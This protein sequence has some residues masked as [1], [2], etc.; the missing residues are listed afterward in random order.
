[1][2]YGG[3]EMRL[4]KSMSKNSQVTADEWFS[5][6]DQD[7][8]RETAIKYLRKLDNK[9]YNR[10]LKAL[11]KYREGDK[12]IDGVDEPEENENLPVLDQPKDKS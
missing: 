3:T 6:L 12:I 2:Y 10:F 8:Q 1:M 7:T 11:E 5:E 4:F 9:N